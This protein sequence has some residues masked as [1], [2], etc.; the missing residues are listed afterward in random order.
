MNWESLGL[1]L[2]LLLENEPTHQTTN[3][4]QSIVHRATLFND[5]S[6]TA[7][8]NFII[9]MAMDIIKTVYYVHGKWGDEINFAVLD[10]SF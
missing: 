8:I 6:K 3:Y 2:L 7:K 9:S 4:L 10:V 1:K 5:T